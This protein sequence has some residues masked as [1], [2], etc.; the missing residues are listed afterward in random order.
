M[1]LDVLIADQDLKLA[2]LYCRF[3][4]GHGLSA[5]AALSGLDCLAMV[6]QQPPDVLVLDRELP[7]NDARGILACLRADG[8]SLPVILTTWND[9]QETM[10]RLVTPPVVLCLRKFFPLPALLGAIH[11]AVNSHEKQLLDAVRAHNSAEAH[12]IEA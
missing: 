11:L 6:H 12:P 9:S 4:A 5:K 1:H 2:R 7:W 3:L 10:R 8:V